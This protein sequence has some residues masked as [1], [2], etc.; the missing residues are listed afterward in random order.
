M[1]DVS[2]M[3][4]VS[5][6]K[7]RMSYEFTQKVTNFLYK[8]HAPSLPIPE[9]EA[10]FSSGTF[11]GGEFDPKF[12]VDV[13]G[14]EVYL[15]GLPSIETKDDLFPGE[16]SFR[17]CAAAQAAYDNGAK[18]VHAV[19][20]D[21]HF[22][23]ADRSASDFDKKNPSSTSNAGRGRIALLQAKLFAASSIKTVFTMELHSELIRDI[24]ADVF[25]RTDALQVFSPAPLFAH[26]LAEHSFF[27]LNNFGEELVL[28]SPD[29]GAKKT[30]HVLLE[31]LHKEH[32]LTG[33]SAVFLKK[34]RR[35]PNNPD[36]LEVLPDPHDP[37]SSN[38][39]TMDGKH[40]VIVDDLVD[41]AGTISEAAK[42]F[43]TEGI[44]TS[45]GQELPASVSTMLVHPVF[46]GRNF[47]S[48]MKKIAS[49]D[50]RELIICNSHPFVEDNLIFPLKKNTSIIRVALLFAEGLAKHQMGSYA[51]A[52]YNEN[53][54]FSKDKVSSLFALKRSTSFT[55][56]KQG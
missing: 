12:R 26:Y 10:V 28:V 27:P 38:Y 3:V 47:E 40:I 35:Q 9:V 33:V 39:T 17:V 13:V 15:F 46:A 44:R 25:G 56:S 55:L 49:A 54:V 23:R 4:L 5:L 42:H 37:Y 22:S 11:S 18:A 45:K 8:Q 32:G 21:L 14:K 51:N 19:L 34:I 7:N 16:L 30:L 50:L 36:N 29:G 43:R 2:R 31:L 20:P 52:V 41:T 1:L 48:A 53:G 6:S 24:Y